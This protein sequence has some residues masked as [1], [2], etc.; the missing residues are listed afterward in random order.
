VRVSGACQ[1]CGAEFAAAQVVT[2]VR[3]AIAYGFYRF[4]DDVD[5]CLGSE[6]EWVAVCGACTKP[7][8]AAA[9]KHQLN[10]RGCGQP[11]MTPNRPY[12]FGREKLT[13]ALRSAL[14]SG[15]SGQDMALDRW[16]ERFRRKLDGQDGAHRSGLRYREEV[17]S[18]RCA[19]RWR[20]KRRAQKRPAAHCAM[21]GTS[22]VPTRRDAQFCSNACRQW[23][24]RQRQRVSS[25][26]A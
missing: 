13:A 10:C 23:A 22:F 16:R 5:R 2:I 9:A 7:A 4:R 15:D 12:S 21:C 24:Y 26:V 17:C 25:P 18:D 6:F 20:R 1:R 14:P 8:E 11:M 3:E 19:Q